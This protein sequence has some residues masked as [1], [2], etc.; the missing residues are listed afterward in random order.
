MPRRMME[1]SQPKYRDRERKKR[2]VHERDLSTFLSSLSLASNF[3][4]KRERLHERAE[5]PQFPSPRSGSVTVYN[6]PSVHARKQWI[7]I[8]FFRLFSISLS[9]LPFAHLCTHTR[10]YGTLK[11]KGGNK[12]LIYRIF[13]LWR[14]SRS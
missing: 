8:N 10:H 6:R 3:A 11:K 13:F 14:G 7:K 1:H 5:K 4:K 9:L 2:Q 12:Q